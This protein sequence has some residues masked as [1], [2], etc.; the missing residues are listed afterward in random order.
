MTFQFSVPEGYGWNLAVR[1]LQ[2]IYEQLRA[3]QSFTGTWDAT[4]NPVGDTSRFRLHM[5]DSRLWPRDE[6]QPQTQWNIWADFTPSM[7]TECDPG[8]SIQ[9]LTQWNIWADFTPSMATDCDP[10]IEMQPQ[11]Q[12]NIWADFTPSMAT[13]CDPGIEM[14]PQIQ[15]DIQA[16]FTSAWMTQDCDPGI[17]IQPLTQWNI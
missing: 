17:S 5:N 16:G 14:Q 2:F 1:R 15:W 7:A 12:W 11:T 13:D 8:T 6:R 4:P 3:L 9:P 10:W